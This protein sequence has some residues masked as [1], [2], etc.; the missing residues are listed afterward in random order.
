VAN[1]KIN[2]TKIQK[3]TTQ[4]QSSGPLLSLASPTL[5]VAACMCLSMVQ[6]WQQGQTQFGG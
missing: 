3:L 4:T 6:M 1:Q 5:A 2:N